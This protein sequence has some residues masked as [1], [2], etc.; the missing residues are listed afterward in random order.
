MQLKDSFTGNCIPL[1][2]IT[3]LTINSPIQKINL[4][5]NMYR[6]IEPSITDSIEDKFNFNISL[7]SFQLSEYCEHIIIYMS[8]FVG[9]SLAKQIKCEPC[10]NSLFSKDNRVLAELIFLK[11]RG[12]L[13]YPSK[14]VIKICRETEKVIRL[15]AKHENQNVPSKLN[16]IKV[17][18]HVLNLFVDLH[19][20]NDLKS[21][22]LDNFPNNC[23]HLVE[24]IRAICQKYFDI[25]VKHI[26]K[27]FNNCKIT[28]RQ[29]LNKTVLFQGK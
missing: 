14:D 5:S 22:Q 15:N 3:I 11:D 16:K 6:S 4:T 17:I 24:L 18:S 20:F 25:R 10:I 29:L 26:T 28:K 13:N 21:H 7:D 8:G 1:E 2:N 19:V 9:K 12:G 27:I 23:S